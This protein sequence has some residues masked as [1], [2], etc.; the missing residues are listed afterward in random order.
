M[1]A[2][3]DAPVDSPGNQDAVGIRA[4]VG[5]N[6][7][8]DHSPGEEVGRSPDEAAAHNRAEDG[9]TVDKR[10]VEDNLPA[11]RSLGEDNLPAQG[12]L[13]EDSLLVDSLLVDTL[14]VDTLPADGPPPVLAPRLVDSLLVDSLLV[15]T[16]PA[17]GP[18]PVLAPLALARVQDS[19]GLGSQALHM[20]SQVAGS[21]TPCC[22]SS[23]GAEA[24]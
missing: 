2:I 9:H 11:E 8:V 22:L 1:H 16:L 23:P 19:Q 10:L 21:V 14:L 24:S 15:D 20:G 3:Q 7:V 5:H 6:Q 18:P 17:D 12:S 13:E 4:A